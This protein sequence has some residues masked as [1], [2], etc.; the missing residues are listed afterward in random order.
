MG[1]KI[2]K[3]APRGYVPMIV[4]RGVEER[5]LVKT[6]L[7][8]H[9]SLANLLD[10]AAQEFGYEQRGILKIPCSLEQFRSVVRHASTK[11]K[12]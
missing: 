10:L 3:E 6:K 11:V 9:P 5:V 7:L 4:G 12:S 8:K 1:R 2:G